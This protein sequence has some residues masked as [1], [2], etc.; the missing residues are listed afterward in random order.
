[1]ALLILALKL[2]ILKRVDMTES[3]FQCGIV[4]IDIILVKIGIDL[5]L[6]CKARV[7]NHLDFEYRLMR[8]KLAFIFENFD[9][10]SHHCRVGDLFYRGADIEPGN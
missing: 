3:L 8:Y 5:L 10:L 1:M 4:M 2:S 9:D 6:G 7:F